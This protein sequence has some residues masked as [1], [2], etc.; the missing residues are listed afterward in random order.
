MAVVALTVGG[1]V[2]GRAMVAA[3]SGA[4]AG[5]DGAWEALFDAY[6]VIRVSDLDETGRHP[7]AVRLPAAGRSRAGSGIATVHDSGAERALVVDMADAVG[8]PF[9]PSAPATVERLE[10][11]I[12]SGLVAGNPLDVWGTGADTEQLFAGLPVG[13]GR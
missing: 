7:G 13:H 5:A 10:R 9:A 2:P 1:S 8:V 12:G 6:G 3:H 4:L 11:L